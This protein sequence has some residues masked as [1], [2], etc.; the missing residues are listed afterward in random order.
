MAGPSDQ[1]SANRPAIS[2]PMTDPT[3]AR[4]VMTTF[5]LVRSAVGNSS[6]P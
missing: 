1:R 3:T 4:P 5:A 2:R 6:G